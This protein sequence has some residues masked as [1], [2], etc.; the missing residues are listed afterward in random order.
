MPIIYPRDLKRGDQFVDEEGR[1]HWLA[2][3]DATF[4]DGRVV[5]RVRHRDGGIDKRVWDNDNTI[6]LRVI[7]SSPMGPEDDK[8]A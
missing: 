1:K 2:L 4:G 8:E 5:V 3:E 6:E 7:R